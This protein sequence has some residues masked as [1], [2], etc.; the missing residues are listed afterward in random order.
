[1]DKKEILSKKLIPLKQNKDIFLNNNLNKKYSPQNKLKILISQKNNN[2]ISPNNK[3]IIGKYNISVNSGNNNEIYVKKDN[4]NNKI[5]KSF[6]LN[7]NDCLDE[8]TLNSLAQENNLLKKEIEIVKSNLLLSDEKEQ[9][10]RKTIQRIKEI[11]KEKEITY[12]NNIN[13]IN[14]YK[15]REFELKNKIKEM[16]VDFNKKEEELNNELSIFKKELFNKN[17]IINDLNNKIK[18]LNEQILNL[19]KIISE[20]NNTIY[21]L[22]NGNQN[23]SN[24]NNINEHT[25]GLTSSKSCNNI[26][27]RKI[28][29]KISKTEKNMHRRKYTNYNTFKNIEK[30]NFNDNTLVDN[31]SNNNLSYIENKNDEKRRINSYYKKIIPKTH[32]NQNSLKIHSLK[33]YYSNKNMKL[34]YNSLNYSI[35]KN[36]NII[37]ETNINKHKNKNIIHFKKTLNKDLIKTERSLNNDNKG[38]YINKN[39]ISPLAKK[40]K[41]SKTNNIIEFNNFSFYLND[42]DKS[43]PNKLINIHD[44]FL[45]N[46]KN[47]NVYIN[48]NNFSQINNKKLLYE[49]KKGLYSN[50][51]KL[52]EI[53]K[54]GLNKNPSFDYNLLLGNIPPLSLRDI[55]K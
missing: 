32:N 23:L 44:E 22:S 12:Q 10:H 46:K 6:L 30:I 33:K 3:L 49:N 4:N 35:N 2:K 19:K 15:K 25:I 8:I 47:N 54:N 36:P 24:N 17:K 39:I 9:L 40:S 37:F 34:N 26:I 11:N 38:N 18:N 42:V 27:S 7:K 28:F 5:N 51:N 21:I 31:N 50:K 55:P 16:E 13:L 41:K 14:E 48:N 43:Q 45:K 29:F 1:M 20:K 53:N 52:I